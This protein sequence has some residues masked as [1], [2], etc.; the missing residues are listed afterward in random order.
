MG[1]TVGPGSF[2]GPLGQ[3]IQCITSIPVPVEFEKK[4]DKFPIIEGNLR[5]CVCVRER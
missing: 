3:K 1:E 4:P 5:V 2:R